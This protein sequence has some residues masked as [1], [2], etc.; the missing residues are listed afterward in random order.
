MP[1]FSNQL[2][3]LYRN[4]A[5]EASFSTLQLKTPANLNTVVAS[6]AK[7]FSARVAKVTASGRCVG[8]RTPYDKWEPLRLT[9][10]WLRSIEFEIVRSV[11]RHELSREVLE[12]E[13]GKR[14]RI[15]YFEMLKWGSPYPKEH[16]FCTALAFKSLPKALAKFLPSPG[17]DLWTMRAA[18]LFFKGAS[19]RANETTWELYNRFD[20]KGFRRLNQGQFFALMPTCW[21]VFKNYDYVHV[22]FDDCK[23]AD[24]WFRKNT[25]IKGETTWELYRRYDPKGERAMHQGHFHSLLPKS[26]RGLSH[27]ACIHLP[28][29]DCAQAERWFRSSKPD[30]R[31]STWDL[32]LRFDPSGVRAMHQG[33]FHALIPRDWRRVGN[34]RKVEATFKDCHEIEQ[35]YREVTPQTLAKYRAI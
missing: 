4:A 2:N 11:S 1:N 19:P 31:E 24:E 22:S 10:F 13:S 32:Y 30:P 33:H 7:R 28:Y 20:R 9:E 6:M 8:L 23:R 35:I 21:R 26:W 3:L 29:A 27:Y 15:K 25:P 12:A 16:R 17:V 5:R 18:R 14:M 34:Y